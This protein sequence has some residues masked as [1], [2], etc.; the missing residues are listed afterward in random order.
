MAEDGIQDF[1]GILNVT[2]KG[3]ENAGKATKFV[4]DAGFQV[5]KGS[6][7]ALAKIIKMLTWIMR[8]LSEKPY[9]KTGGKVANKVLQTK[10][11]DL[12]FD[13]LHLLSAKNVMD[14]VNKTHQDSYAYKI[15]ETKF[16]KLLSPTV[17]KKDFD[18]L[19]KKYGLLWSPVPNFITDTKTGIVE[20]KFAYSKQQEEAML[21][22]KAQLNALIQQRLEACKVPKEAKEE[23]AKNM[24]DPTA[25]GKPLMQNLDEIGIGAVSD[26]EFEAAM[27]ATYPKYDP[28]EFAPVEPS[29]EKKTASI[30]ITENNEYARESAKGNVKEIAF[31]KVLLKTPGEHAVTVV[32]DEYPNAA[33]KIKE[34]DV[35]DLQE[36][37]DEKG[38][39]G[40]K[41]A[42]KKDAVYEFE[43]YHV[44]P[45][46]K[47]VDFTQN[48]KHYEMTFKE[49]ERMMAENAEKVKSKT[50]ALQNVL[51]ERKD[52]LPA[53][54]K[55]RTPRK[56]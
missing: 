44:N 42:I 16:N 35:L 17:L 4:A 36:W 27:I 53:A 6:Y 14:I 43:V 15:D 12:H 28:M 51:V 13:T 31:S 26:K 19:A 52:M 3:I 20:F 55:P 22:V 9:Y 11:Q 7:K 41:M 39:V 37:K 48:P 18:N 30:E 33:I 25:A 2:M 32:L 40:Y 21:E 24:V 47:K 23:I 29:E 56:N 50:A 5:A 10:F 38:T 34:S 54:P 8:T 49:F 46:S 45:V 1:I